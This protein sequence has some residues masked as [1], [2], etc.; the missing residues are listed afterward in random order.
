MNIQDAAKILNLTGDYT[1]ELV[2]AAYRKACS[3]YHPDRNPA[4]LEMM[5]LV[6]QAYEAIR[7]TNGTAKAVEE[8]DLSSY[9]QDI[10]N[11]LSNIINLG[12]DIEICGAWVWLHGDTKPHREILKESGF[13]WAPKKMLWYFRPED[14]KSKGR[15]KFSMDEIRSAYGSDKVTARERTKL[16]AA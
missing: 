6:N 11:A 7:D 16:R 12:F 5:K 14:Y 1:P 15:G 13:R 4:G 9:G 2:K 8:G 10:F 3:A